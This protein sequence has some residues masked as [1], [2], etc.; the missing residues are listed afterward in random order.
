[1]AISD[2]IVISGAV[3]GPTDQAVLYRLLKHVG[4]ELGPV[5]GGKGK[6]YLRKHIAGYNE[7]ARHSSWIVLVDL[8][9]DADCAPPFRESWIPRPAPHM[10][11]RVAVRA[12]ES[13]FFADVERLARFLSVGRA[14]IPTLP[15][16][17]EDPKATMVELARQSRKRDIREDMVPRP[18][19]GRKVGPA[20][21]SRLM[22]FAQNSW[23]PQVAAARCDSLRRCIQRLR[24][25]AQRGTI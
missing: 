5:Y 19:S 6:S 20:Y 17:V 24:E 22:E 2:R 18:G 9:Q 11:F 8:N 10:C 3:E 25:V 1:M 23:R 21:A 7:A 16:Q 12:V 14:R 13:W 15:E 4:V